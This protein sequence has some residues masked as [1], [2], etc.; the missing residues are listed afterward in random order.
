M[1][2]AKTSELHNTSSAVQIPLGTNLSKLVTDLNLSTTPINRDDEDVGLIPISIE[3][4]T[5]HRNTTDTIGELKSIVVVCS[6]VY[7]QR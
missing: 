2:E 1:S 6:V 4:T 3:P 5:T 7:A